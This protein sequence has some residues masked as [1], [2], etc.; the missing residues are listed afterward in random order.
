M[1]VCV[2]F[3]SLPVERAENFGKVLRRHIPKA[4]Q[5]RREDAAV[6]AA[7]LPLPRPGG[8]PGGSPLPRAAP[9]ERSRWPRARPAWGCVC[10]C[11]APPGRRF[12]SQPVLLRCVKLGLSWM[13]RAV[14]AGGGLHLFI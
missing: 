5:P 11:V 12:V 8:L 2:C 4:L 13:G 6:P 10:V 9:A 3:Q 14:G 1:C 7:P